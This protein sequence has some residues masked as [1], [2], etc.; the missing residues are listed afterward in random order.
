MSEVTGI[1]SVALVFCAIG[2]LFTTS[3]IRQLAARVERLERIVKRMGIE[4]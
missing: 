2:G 3:A 1:I 4:P